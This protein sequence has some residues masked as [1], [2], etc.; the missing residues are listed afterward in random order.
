[1]W[2]SFSFF[3]SRWHDCK[4]TSVTRKERRFWELFVLFFCVLC[5]VNKTRSCK[6]DLDL[7]LKDEEL[8]VCSGFMTMI[9]VPTRPN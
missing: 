9:L 8:R 5:S 7:Y 1:M 2:M 4:T 6:L 3:S